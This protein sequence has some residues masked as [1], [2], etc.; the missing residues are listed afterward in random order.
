MLLPTVRGQSLTV[1]LRMPSILRASTSFALLSSLALA[2]ALVTTGMPP[3]VRKIVTHDHGEFWP[4]ALARH[5]DGTVT[6]VGNP[7]LG[8]G[9][10]AVPLS[11]V[12]DMDRLEAFAPGD[13]ESVAV[14]GSAGLHFVRWDQ[15]ARGY[16]LTLVDAGAAN[17]KIVRTAPFAPHHTVVTVAA[18][19]MSLRVYRTMNLIGT[20]AVAGPVHDLEVFRN[21]AGAARFLLRTD[22]GV[23]C[24]GPGGNQLWSVP[25]AGGCFVRWPANE[26]V[27]VGWIHV[28]EEGTWALW[29]LGDDG[30]IGA[31]TPP[32]P[33]DLTFAIGNTE[34]VIAAFAARADKDADDEVDLVLKTTNGVSL[35]DNESQNDF[36]QFTEVAVNLAVSTACVPDLLVTHAGKRLRLVDENT[37]AGLGWNRVD[38]PLTIAPDD[39]LSLEL[40]GGGAGGRVEASPSSHT[41][42]RF[43]VRATQE[44][45][46]P[47]LGQATFFQVVA[48]RQEE[49][50]LRADDL[51]ENNLLF[52]VT[53][54][55]PAGDTVW[56]LRTV[57]E[58]PH[59]PTGAPNLY[60]DGSPLYW[61]T[62]RLC[63]SESGGAPLTVSEPVTFVTSL[64]QAPEVAGYLAGFTDWLAPLDWAVMPLG[65]IV[66][67][68][69]QKSN[70]PPPPPT[71]GM[72]TPRESTGG[73]NIQN[74]GGGS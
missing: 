44:A 22:A 36:P 5:G 59:S 3:N 12:L 33:V 64:S 21:A 68:V 37:G 34:Q 24:T 70:L 18:D 65:G 43:R 42:I 49:P 29:L 41:E 55:V 51:S 23:S 14:V 9:P 72:P 63:R 8:G 56:P 19:G 25:G 50:G 60:W 30:P 47:F 45:L 53:G 38:L 17:A 71:Q 4:G 31:P 52:Q 62:V 26:T 57:L 7:W 73:E 20:P 2:Q 11:G 58:Q 69:I 48:W 74:L 46:E 28:T 10:R 13:A 16:E 39:G 6:A 66:I 15:V 27:R 67:G 61:L 1:A 35:L 54:T 40:D 32:P